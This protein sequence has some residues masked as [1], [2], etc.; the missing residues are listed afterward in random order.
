MVGGGRLVKRPSRTVTLIWPHVC[1]VRGPATGEV[2]E[3]RMGKPVPIPE[4]DLKG[5]LKRWAVTPQPDRPKVTVNGE[6][7]EE[8][9]DKWPT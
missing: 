6:P 7:P 4:A 5:L 1:R 3:L 9:E 8:Q 2:Y